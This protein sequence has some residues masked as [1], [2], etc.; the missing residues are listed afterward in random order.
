MFWRAIMLLYY[1]WFISFFSHTLKGKG[2]DF[3]GYKGIFHPSTYHRLST[4]L[5]FQ[6]M[7][8]ISS[9]WPL[10][11]L[12]NITLGFCLEEMIGG[13]IKTDGRKEAER[14]A[15]ILSLA[16]MMR[17]GREVEEEQLSLDPPNWILPFF[18]GWEGRNKS[19]ASKWHNYL[20]KIYYM[21]Y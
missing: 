5:L 2:F 15:K 13:R 14:R 17:E 6:I 10:S 9:I 18:E 7:D 8:L 16:R 4:I 11:I 20:Q 12:P 21:F 3:V 19:I 1:S